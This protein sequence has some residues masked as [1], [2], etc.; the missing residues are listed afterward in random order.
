M[1]QITDSATGVANVSIDPAILSAALDASSDNPVVEIIV[2]VALFAA[3]AVPIVIRM[4]LRYR[5]RQDVQKTLRAAV[6]RGQELTPEI[7]QHIGQEPALVNRDL[8][9]GVLAAGVG[10]GIAAFGFLLGEEDAV[11][12][13]IAIGALPVLIGLAY[14]GLWI[15]T[16]RGK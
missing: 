4:Y 13:L 11:R 10:A 2:P 8:R 9:R 1:N 16:G 3:I 6:E 12:P 15:F 14:I 7:L 5:N